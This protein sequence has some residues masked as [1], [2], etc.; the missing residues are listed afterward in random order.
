[1]ERRNKINLLGFEAG[2]RS[3]AEQAAFNVPYARGI[4]S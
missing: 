3:D 2:S 1:M 4:P